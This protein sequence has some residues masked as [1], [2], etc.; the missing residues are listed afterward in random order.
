[1]AGIVTPKF[2]T[3]YI[4]FLEWGIEIWNYWNGTVET[5]Y[6]VEVDSFDFV[7]RFLQVFLCIEHLVSGYVATCVCVYACVC[8]CVKGEGWTNIE[9]CKT[10][11]K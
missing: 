9:C 11:I 6:L 3:V 5:A 10:T 8:V 2:Y 7:H 4:N 1:M